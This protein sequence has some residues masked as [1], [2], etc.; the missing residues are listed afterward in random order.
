MVLFFRLSKRQLPNL[1]LCFSILVQFSC[2]KENV[3]VVYPAGSNEDINTWITDSLKRY[4]YWTD[5]LPAHADISKPPLVYFNTVKNTADPFS[6][7]I[8]PSDPTSGIANSKSKFGFD[9]S[10]IVEQRTGLVIGVIKLVLNDSPASRNS[11]VR[12]D[13]INKINGKQLT[14]DNAKDL[15]SEL[16]SGNSVTLSI[17]R[18]SGDQL[19]ADRDVEISSG[20]TFEQPATSKVIA[21]GNKKIGYLYINDFSPGLAASLYSVFAGFK[22]SGISDLILDLRYNSGGQVAE[23]AGLTAM[24]ANGINYSTPFIIYQGNKN[25]GRRKE[26]VG[27]AATY[28][29]TVNFELALQYNL[30]LKQIYILGTGATASAS[31][32]MINNLK[33]YMQV[34]LIG[35]VTRG[36]DAASFK[37]SDMRVPKRVAWEMHPIVYKLFNAVGSGDYSGGINPD[38]SVNELATLP[39]LPLGSENDPLINTAITIIKDA[40]AQRVTLAAQTKKRTTGALTV[41]ADSKLSASSSSVVVTHR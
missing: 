17:A 8:L 35:E 40:H 30:G 24:I 11:L 41:L 32:V 1:L 3:K 25:G 10:T 18:I 29:G 33:P 5:Q 21:A 36:K 20:A 31:E 16:L 28:D 12:G 23:A 19:I 13:Y 2:K 22:S 37:I 39:L 34:T 14:R 27:D 6:Y 26:S 7:I 38:I 4:Y 15:Q 9:Y